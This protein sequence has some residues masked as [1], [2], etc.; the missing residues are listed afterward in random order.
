MFLKCWQMPY[1]YLGKTE[2]YYL[3]HLLKFNSFLLYIIGKS[4]S[5]ANVVDAARLYFNFS[6]SF[7]IKEQ[8]CFIYFGSG[9][10]RL[11]HNLIFWYKLH[12]K[13]LKLCLTEAYQFWNVLPFRL[14]ATKE[15][16]I[17]V[18]NWILWFNRNYFQLPYLPRSACILVYNWNMVLLDWQ[19]T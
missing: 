7:L 11:W 12:W 8:N 3:K 17:M 4:H 15:I 18:T 6:S 9:T 13:L 19:K 2:G 5:E 16:T 10:N 14:T 1:H